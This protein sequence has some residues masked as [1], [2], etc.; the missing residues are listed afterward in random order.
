MN[1]KKTIVLPSFRAGEEPL[2]FQRIVMQWKEPL[3]TKAMLFHLE[4]CLSVVACDPELFSTV[5]NS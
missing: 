3:N 5:D 1:A 2:D 4:T